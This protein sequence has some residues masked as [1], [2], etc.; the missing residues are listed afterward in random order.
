MTQA[1]VILEIQSQKR[2]LSEHSFALGSAIWLGRDPS[3]NVP[4][5]DP[6]VSRRHCLIQSD[7]SGMQVVDESANGTLVDGQLLRRSARA[8]RGK[9]MLV[10]GPFEVRARMI[11]LNLPPLA[12]TP[13][14]EL[15]HA[16]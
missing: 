5:V 9:T 11:G 7:A 12:E 15:S 13:R 1:A 16:G 2:V 8:V 14:L 4:L 10:I 6:S 3:C